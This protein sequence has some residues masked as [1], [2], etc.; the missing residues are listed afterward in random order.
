MSHHVNQGR[1]VWNR[2]RND[3]TNHNAQR[4]RQAGGQNSSNNSLPYLLQLA[5]SN[6]LQRRL[7]LILKSFVANYA[8][9]SL[10]KA[11]RQDFHPAL[12]CKMHTTTEIPPQ[13][14]NFPLL[15]SA[16]SWVASTAKERVF[17]AAPFPTLAHHRHGLR[18][19]RI[20]SSI[21]S[22]NWHVKV[23]L[24]SFL[25]S[26]NFQGEQGTMR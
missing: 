15:I 19:H 11:P 2:E 8:K 24:V 5:R 14:L 1:G 18:Q 16:Q 12:P 20:K 13:P 10:K 23:L 22:V 26:L 17:P 21:K 4:S 9:L 7:S 3:S 6:I 25:V